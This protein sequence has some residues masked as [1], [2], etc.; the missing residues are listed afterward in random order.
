LS[1]GDDEK[2]FYS[3][4]ARNDVLD[5]SVGEVLLFWVATNV[6]ERQD[7]NRR[8]VWER[9]RRIRRGRTR[10]CYRYADRLVVILFYVSD[11]PEALA[12]QCL[13]QALLLAI[14]RDCRPDRIDTGGQRRVRDD[15]SLPNGGDEFVFAYD[16]LTVLDH[17]GQEIEHFGFDR[18]DG[19]AAAQ[20]APITIQYEIFERKKQLEAP[21]SGTPNRITRGAGRS[22]KGKNNTIR[23]KSQ[24]IPEAHRAAA[25]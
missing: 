8:L 18:H 4:Q 16:A 9:Q 1:C 17:I 5:K 24:G 19:R 14:V 3:R 22:R 25:R 7:G 13:E 21:P 2:P 23:R 6:L 10:V 11:E 20:L 12:R 15:A